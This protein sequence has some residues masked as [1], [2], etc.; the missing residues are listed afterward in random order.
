MKTHIKERLDRFM[1]VYRHELA[2]AVA[3]Y[4]TEYPWSRSKDEE[5]FALVVDRV[6]VA[7]E[8]DGIWG[9]SLFGRTIKATAE[10]IGVANT[11]TQLNLWLLGEIS[12]KPYC[13]GHSLDCGC[14]T[15]LGFGGA[16]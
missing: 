10:R 3:A 11:Y 6:R 13:I 2:K 7:I 12:G 9:L 1:L 8:R 15:C 4:P 5:A 16:A 14:A